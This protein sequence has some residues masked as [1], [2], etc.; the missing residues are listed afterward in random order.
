M[1]T[2][3]F[4]SALSLLLAAGG[5]SKKDSQPA[6]T[7]PADSVETT[8]DTSPATPEEPSVPVATTPGA[9]SGEYPNLQVLPKSWG[10]AELV[11]YMKSV[12]TGLGVQCDHCHVVDSMGDETEMK[13]KAR[14]MMEMT[15]S[16]DGEFLGGEG[17]L[18]CITCH[19]GKTE[20]GGLM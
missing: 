3:L 20:P 1:R 2:L 10:E 12:S 19:K 9:H 6:P 14:A 15:K 5:C 18:A 13:G 11:T 8:E 7:T 16:L 17:K 4:T